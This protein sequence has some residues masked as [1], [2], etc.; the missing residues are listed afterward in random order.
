MKV[1]QLT[2]HESGQAHSEAHSEDV[3]LPF[4]ISP[5]VNVNQ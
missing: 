3:E 1:G 2:E 5:V 4:H